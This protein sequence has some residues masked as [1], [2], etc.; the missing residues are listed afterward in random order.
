[1]QSNSV[2]FPEL[3]RMAANCAEICLSDKKCTVKF[4]GRGVE[5]IG[6]DKFIVNLAGA[7]LVQ[8][9]FAPDQ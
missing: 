9:I 6:D 3:L 1:M 5:S 8:V 2:T 4:G 7:V